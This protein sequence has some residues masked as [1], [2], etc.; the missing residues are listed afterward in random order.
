MPP[1]RDIARGHFTPR[2]LRCYLAAEICLFWGLIL[3]CWLQYPEEHAFSILT[4]TF[5]FLG[6]FNDDRNPGGWWLF[7]IAM[8]GWG[9]ATAPI[10]RYL[11]RTIAGA[12]G[13][14][15]RAVLV[16]LLMG[17]VGITMVGLF[18]DA[19]AH[20]LGE[21]RWTDLH[22]FGAL[23]LVLGF[24]IGIPWLGVLA[25]R[26]ARNPALDE[27]ARQAFRR[28][29]WPHWF[30]ILVT[31]IALFFLIRWEIIYPGLK[32]A[33]EAE[34]REFGSRWREGMNTVYSFPL[35]DNV[36]VYTLWIYFTCAA[37]TVPAPR[38]PKRS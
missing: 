27:S 32:A 6:S 11:H 21:V 35:W 33:A 19:R 15:S 22:Y 20:I 25:G 4:H 10:V 26:A 5:S 37:L 18:P 38:T 36:F 1:F 16:L 9:V 3:I 30:F 2:T 14:R 34:G 31:A 12:A 28:A 17:C 23:F 7:C 8:T 13:K 24:L 29:R